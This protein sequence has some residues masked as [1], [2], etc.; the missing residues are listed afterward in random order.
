MARH[1]HEISAPSRIDGG[2][3]SGPDRL[4]M[5]TV[6]A[7]MWRN[8][9]A[10]G[11]AV[12]DRAPSRTLLEKIIRESD[13]TIEEWC[14]RFDEMSDEDNA[15]LSVRQLQRWM[16]GQADNARPAAR[17]VAARLGGYHF[18][19]LLAPPGVMAIPAPPLPDRNAVSGAADTAES[20]LL[21]EVTIMAAH[22][23]SRHAAES[24]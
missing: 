9:Q 18:A 22:E 10:K 19:T 17:R 4:S 14:R 2:N 3:G 7:T 16:A 15:T 21:E 5:V 11:A 1:W 24:D 6:N 20:N 8:T 23:S 13:H 12:I